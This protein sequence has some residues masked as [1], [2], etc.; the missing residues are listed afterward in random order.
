MPTKQEVEQLLAS[1]EH[2]ELYKQE[3][4]AFD[5]LVSF[6]EDCKLDEALIALCI[7]VLEERK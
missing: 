6:C 1:V 4:T 7:E 2:L 3:K 5:H